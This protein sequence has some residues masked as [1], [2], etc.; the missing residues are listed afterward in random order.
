MKWAFAPER[1]LRSIPNEAWTGE[2]F[3]ID[4]ENSERAAAIKI[5]EPN[6]WAFRFSERLKD[7]NRVWTTEVGIAEKSPNEV[8]LA[9]D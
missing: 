7:T 5:N 1:N 2:T 6:Y 8:I 3:E 9:V 4:A